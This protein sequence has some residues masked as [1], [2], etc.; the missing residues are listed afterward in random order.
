M[1]QGVRGAFRMSDSGHPLDYSASKSALRAR[2]LA[3]RQALT[4]PERSDAD[5][6][7]RRVLRDLVT[8]LPA[9]M[10]AG[11]TVTAYVPFGT[12]PG[13]PQLP[14]T[15]AAALA[16]RPDSGRLLLPVLR[17]DLDLEWA[18][19]DGRLA[20]GPHQGM[21]EP[22]GR[23]LGREA[24]GAAELLVVPAVAVDRRGFRLGRGGGSY[25]R[26]L[27]RAADSAAVVA[28][29]YDGELL[30]EV[31]VEPHDR[32]VTAAITPRLGLVATG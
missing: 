23:R 11:L 25:D 21:R 15:L 32:R 31:P 17:P 28:L 1:L 4:V 12:E 10:G 3:A 19:Y 2:L 26:A 20:P 27:A 16:A 13:G 24:V 8:R 18:I 5:D 14:D 30:D 29:L 6:R 7:L 9:P 22:P